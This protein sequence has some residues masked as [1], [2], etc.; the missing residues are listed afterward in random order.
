M[1]RLVLLL[2]LDLYRRLEKVAAAEDRDP[3]QQARTI[4]RTV[5]AEMPSPQPGRAAEGG[6]S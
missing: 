6:K 1:K 3:T 4:L 5:L 2:P